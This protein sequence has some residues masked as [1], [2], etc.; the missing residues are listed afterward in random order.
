MYMNEN[1]K[2]TIILGA[3]LIVLLILLIIIDVIR[4][5]KEKKKSRQRQ[6]RAMA[7]AYNKADFFREIEPAPSLEMKVRK[8]EFQ[9]EELEIDQEVVTKTIESGFETSLS[10]GE[11]EDT[12]PAS[13]E[14]VFTVKRTD[15]VDYDSSECMIPNV[16][17]SVLNKDY[18]KIKERTDFLQYNE[19]LLENL[20]YQSKMAARKR[21]ERELESAGNIMMVSDDDPI[22][23][24]SGVSQPAAATEPQQQDI[25]GEDVA[26]QEDIQDEINKYLVAMETQ[27]KGIQ[28]ANKYKESKKPAQKGLLF[29]GLGMSSTAGETDNSHKVE[30]ITEVPVPDKETMTGREYKKA[31]KAAAKH[32]EENIHIV[33]EE[34]STTFKNILAKNTELSR[35]RYDSS[36]P[37]SKVDALEEELLELNV[38]YKNLSKTYNRI[39]N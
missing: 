6:E 33:V 1:M 28:K 20:L 12:K 39:K 35:A 14:D 29:S 9:M 16:D 18:K 22:P 8:D 37:Q 32:K 24:V 10:R 7:S 15:V 23:A 17:A 13:S 36:I 2:F 11:P 4:R 25:Y 30:T 31:A 26:S 27:L 19:E 38:K 5:A 34:M 21:K 3:A